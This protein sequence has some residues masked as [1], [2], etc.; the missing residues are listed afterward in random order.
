MRL[1]RL[2]IRETDGTEPPLEVRFDRDIT[3]VDLDVVGSTRVRLALEA[4][5]RGYTDFG[6]AHVTI[7]DIE[8]EVSPELAR[9]LS[10]HLG[11]R[12][13]ILDPATS[14]QEAG[15][16]NS[17]MAVSLRSALEML[18][19]VSP[20]L[21]RRSVDVALQAV[22][23][24]QRVLEADAQM[25]VMEA[26]GRQANAQIALGKIA[27][28]RASVGPLHERSEDARRKARR[29]FSGPLAYHRY[30][31]VRDQEMETL[32]AVDFESFEEFEAHA[33]E[34]EARYREELRLAT[35][36]HDRALRDHTALV[37]RTNQATRA[38][39]LAVQEYALRLRLRQFADREPVSA[40]DQNALHQ[41]LHIMVREGVGL[42][43]ATSDGLV[44]VAAEWLARAE[45]HGLAEDLERSVVAHAEPIA[46][47]GTTP[48]ILDGL[49]DGVEPAAAA[50]AL[51]TLD[52]YVGTVQIVSLRYDP[53]FV[54]WAHT[55]EAN[56]RH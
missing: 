23:G 28:W 26:A 34:A 31:K 17:I 9:H 29:R 49:F 30:A 18:R 40:D 22:L 12:N 2:E 6:R 3:V 53:A 56:P 46:V 36:E 43:D 13:R 24:D 51:A 33:D 21:D 45:S 25:K 10:F 14:R 5:L 27:H 32:E 37:N 54:R 39:V 20:R 44:A 50:R 35:E 16:A 42:A 47:V 8:I 19:V 41:T 11:D 55:H 15:R 7:D 52:P 38:R 4:L 48:L 1:S